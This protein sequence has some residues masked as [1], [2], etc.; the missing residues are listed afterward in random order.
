[1]TMP[2]SQVSFLQRLIGD[3]AVEREAGSAA[4][5]IAENE[6]IGCV[7]GIRVAYTDRDLEKASALLKSRGFPTTAPDTKAM[8]SAALGAGSE[9]TNA[10]RVS[11]GMLAIVPLG[12]GA[13]F[14]HVPGCFM[15]MPAAFAATLAYEVVLVSENLEPLR[16]LHE[17]TWLDGYLKGRPTLGIFRGAPGFFRTDVAADFLRNDER[18]TLAFFD[19]DPAGLAMASSL[20]RREALCFPPMTLLEAETRLH[21]RTGLFTNSYHTKRQQLEGVVD[22]EISVAW[23]SL[24][25]LSAGL[26]QENFPR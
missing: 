21:N 10:L 15:A 1:M 17:Y 11:D 19:F 13:D 20:P 2:N 4:R 5:L 6:G 3:Q 8:R 9:K 14:P 25:S 7:S 18:P 23:R 22:R 16:S 26:G 12:M 24:K